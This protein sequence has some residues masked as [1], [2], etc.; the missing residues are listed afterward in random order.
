[1]NAA[2]NSGAA[3]PTVG[4]EGGWAAITFPTIVGSTTAHMLP[5]PSGA[6][7][8]INLGRAE[9]TDVAD[10]SYLP[11]LP[12]IGFAIV[13]AKKTGSGADRYASSYNHKYQV[14]VQ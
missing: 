12:V 13:Q 6:T 9:R 8:L 3:V 5:A 1:M 14:S 7:Q 4:K 10:R 2:Q 11:G